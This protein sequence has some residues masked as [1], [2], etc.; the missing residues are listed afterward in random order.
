MGGFT[1]DDRAF[2]AGFSAMTDHF[3]KN[4]Q[5]GMRRFGEAAATFMRSHID[6]KS[7]ELAGSVGV[8]EHFDQGDH[9]YLEVGAFEE[10]AADPHGLYTEFGTSRETARPFARPGLEE[11]ARDFTVDP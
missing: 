1:V 7:G 11:A 3:R 10:G 6:S 5:T 8:Q 2:M 9:P 4:S